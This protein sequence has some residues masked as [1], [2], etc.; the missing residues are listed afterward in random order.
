MHK[1]G[2]YIFITKN[3]SFNVENYIII[4]QGDLQWPQ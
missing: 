3:K 1:K 4:K 2:L